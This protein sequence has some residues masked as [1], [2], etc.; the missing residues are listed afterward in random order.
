MIGRRKTRKFV[1]T[2]QEL[3]AEIHETF[4]TEVDR[5]LADAKNEGETTTDQQ[6]KIDKAERLRRLGFTNTKTASQAR[7]EEARIQAIIV[8]NREKKELREMINY[9]SMKYPFYKFITEES[10]LKICQKYNLIY[11]EVERYLGEVPDKNLEAIEKFKIEESDMA[12]I[13]RHQR[14]WDRGSWK[15]TFMRVDKWKVSQYNWKEKRDDIRSGDDKYE[16][17][18]CSLEI[19]APQSD[20]NM[21]N[22]EV[23]DFK[24]V[25][26]KKEI[27]DPVVLQ[28][29]VYGDTWNMKKAYLIVTAW[30][31]EASDPDV[32]NHIM[33]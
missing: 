32:L 27:P 31:D 11:G 28:P 25:E 33:N 2:T 12:F 9:F 23:K 29:V 6:D 21:N 1:Q 14:S 22:M 4:F 24:I 19:A 18:R 17:A 15:K 20:F 10:V 3:V 7:T 16:Y 8:E 30:G 13:E 5:L 26:K